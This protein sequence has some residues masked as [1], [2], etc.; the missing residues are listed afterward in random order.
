MFVINATCNDCRL[1]ALNFGALNVVLNTWVFLGFFTYEIWA[2]FKKSC[3]NTADKHPIIDDHTFALGIN[4]RKV[5]RS[6]LSVIGSLLKFIAILLVT[7]V[8]YI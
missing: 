2:E 4:Y 3:G 1:E 6:V 8:Y 7:T 5:R